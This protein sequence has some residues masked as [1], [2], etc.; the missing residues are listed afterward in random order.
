M[1]AGER[2]A[3]KPAVA[4]VRGARRC[5]AAVGRDALVERVRGERARVTIVQAPQRLQRHSSRRKSRDAARA[6]AAW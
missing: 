1:M 5:Y 4:D 3:V 6:C 2:G